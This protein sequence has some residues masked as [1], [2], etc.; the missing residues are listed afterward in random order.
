MY[1]YEKS[2]EQGVLCAQYNCGVMYY[3][4][5]GTFKNRAKAR[6]LFQKLAEQTEDKAVQKK[7]KKALLE[8]LLV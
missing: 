2:A 3:K 1:W 7:A 5:E 4:G 6:Q 8:Y